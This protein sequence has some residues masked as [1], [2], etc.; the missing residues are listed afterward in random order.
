M[1]VILSTDDE[2]GVTTLLRPKLQNKV[3]KPRMYQVLLHNDDFTPR[4]FV[5][6]VLQ[7]VFAKSE[8][9]AS[10]VMLRAHKSGMA[11]VAVYSFGIA[12]TK[13]HKANGM[14]QANELPLR[15]TVEPV[16]DGEDS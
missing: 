10:E 2:H 3:K 16:D 7:K 13:A 8:S 1:S 4:E 14:G 9:Q 15:F 5:V 12:E 11:R 6:L